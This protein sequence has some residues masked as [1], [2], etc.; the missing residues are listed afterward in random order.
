L[1]FSAVQLSFYAFPLLKEA[2]T[3][4]AEKL[5]PDPGE[6]VSSQT[7]FQAAWKVPTFLTP[8]IG[9]EKAV[10]EICDHVQQR[11]MRLVTLLGPGGVGKTRVAAQVTQHLRGFFANG[12][13]FVSLSSVQD[14]SQVLS[15]IAHTLDISG[16]SAEPLLEQIKAFLEKKDC[17][18][19]L[20]NFEHVMAAA[21]DIEQILLSCPLVYILVTSRMVLHLLGEQQYPLPPL[22]LPTQDE[23]INVDALARSPAVTLF[24]QQ[25][26]TMLPGFRLT[27]EN[28]RAVADICIH[29]DGLPLAIELATA[30]IKLLSPHALLKALS[31]RFTL[32]TS[33]MTSYPVRQQTLLKTLE[34]SYQLLSEEEQALFRLCALFANGWTLD[35]VEALVKRKEAPLLS[36]IKTLM[37]LLDNCLLYQVTEEDGAARLH[38]LETMQAYGR[39]CLQ[40]RTELQDG[41]QRHAEYYLALAEEGETFLKGPEQVLWVKRLEKEK[42]NF[43]VALEWFLN[44]K[45]EGSLLR[46][47]R[48]L[49]RFWLLRGYW[50]EGR[51]WMKVALAL[52]SSQTEPTLRAQVLQRFGELAFYQQDGDSAQGVLE[53]CLVICPSY[54]LREEQANASTCLSMIVQKQGNIDKAYRLLEEAEVLCRATVLLWEL[55]LVLRTRGL[56]AW[57]Q[58]DISQAETCARESIALA[59]QTGDQALLAKALSLQSAVTMHQDD[60]LETILLNQEIL[61]IA[62]LLDD[63]YLLATTLQ[64]QGYLE[65]HAHHYAEALILTQKGLLLFRELNYKRLT[66]NALHTQGYIAFHQRNLFFA[67][68]SFQEGLSLA[69][70]LSDATLIGWHMLGL[71]S[72]ASIQSRYGHAA[73]LLGA[74]AQ[75]LDPKQVMNMVEQ[76]EYTQVVDEVRLHLG[77]EQFAQRWQEGEKFTVQDVLSK[78]NANDP[79]LLEIAPLQKEP[80]VREALSVDQLT[81]R[82]L[83]VLRLLTQ[84]LTSAQIATQLVIGLVT[85]NSHVRSIYSKLGVTSRAAATRYA[86]EHQ[87]L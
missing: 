17:F 75:H 62:E 15:H 5:A 82:E 29:L 69:S 70:E 24:L 77:R 38:M 26:Q 74:A 44:Q 72:L 78:S 28:A 85:V 12:I 31:Q 16:K 49:S 9:R 20:D 59:R 47:C 83:E 1:F 51:T 45:E 33:S 86:L 55:A 58:G 34:W 43:R 25:A 21:L 54:H 66:A 68:A 36:P 2:E 56:L 53:D 27:Q 11:G 32:L 14:H 6:D 71:A 80:A 65:A 7:T 52:A 18:L 41:C 3:M 81:R 67:L 63:T 23:I 61:R 8:L 84:G 73:H 4:T 57:I 87:L 60:Y 30:R 35:A 48:A 50:N 76:A 39:L 79:A 46:L 42:E 13:Y 64:N 37:S 10:G 22:P 19:I 40:E